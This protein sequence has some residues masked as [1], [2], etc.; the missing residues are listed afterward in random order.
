MPRAKILVVDHEVQWTLTLSEL[1]I[2]DDYEMFSANSVKDAMLL[3]D[4]RNINVVIA[5][6][7]SMPGADGAAFLE[8]MRQ[9]YAEVSVIVHTA[10]ASVDQAVKA[11]KL[12]AFDY[13]EKVDDPAAL[14]KVRER[15]RQAVLEMGTLIRTAVAD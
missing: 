5:D 4:S 1:L 3:L 13:L 8:E 12:G 7:N 6:I 11:T 2:Q 9:V 15:V 10:K 14:V